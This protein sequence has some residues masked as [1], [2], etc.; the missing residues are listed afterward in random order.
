MLLFWN[1]VKEEL[2]YKGL[3][4]KELAAST[5]ISYNTLQSWMTK[6]RLP[7]AS[8]AVKI[9]AALDVSVEFLVTGNENSKLQD[10]AEINQMIHDLRHLSS[11]DLSIVKT[12]L[13]R[14][15][16]KNL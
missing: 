1:K 10:N 4:Q 8:D 7:D 6:D 13:R 15:S 2:G 11:D 5:G 16:S 9:A 14:L 3:S 12:I